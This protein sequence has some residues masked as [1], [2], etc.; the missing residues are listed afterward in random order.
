VKIALGLITP[1][2]IGVFGAARAEA[3]CARLPTAQTQPLVQGFL[4][5]PESFLERFP[6]GGR[7][8]VGS[9][10]TLVAS[11]PDATLDPIIKALRVANAAQ[12]RSIGL[13]LGAAARMCISAGDTGASRR[14]QEIVRRN[15]DSEVKAGFAASFYE[16]STP[17]PLSGAPAPAGTP[18]QRGS[19]LPPLAS[20]SSP[21]RPSPLSDPFGPLR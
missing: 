10:R 21:L 12:R 15:N 16:A 8:L 9:V 17:P 3:N 7:E 18:S 2:L 20:G 14:I 11:D 5:R 1:L 6:G 4:I 19:L 13:G